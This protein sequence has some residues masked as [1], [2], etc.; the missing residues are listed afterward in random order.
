M[1]LGA[2]PFEL[3]LAA[4]GGFLICI[5]SSLHLLISGK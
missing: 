3:V 2:Y 4:I 5:A 1:I